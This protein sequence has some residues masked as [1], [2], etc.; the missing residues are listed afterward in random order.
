MTLSQQSSGREW[1]DQQGNLRQD[2]DIYVADLAGKMQLNGRSN[3]IHAAYP[4]GS[5]QT[6]QTVLQI[7]P[8]SP[9]DGFK[10]VN[11]TVETTRPAGS[12]GI[13]RETEVLVPDANGKLQT[14]FSRRVQEK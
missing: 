4:D 10:L 8:V 6:T 11:K 9:A 3:L 2:T 1:K 13:E 5:E 12:G 7:S 14:T